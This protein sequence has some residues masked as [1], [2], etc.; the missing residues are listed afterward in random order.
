MG[1]TLNL[2]AVTRPVS[3]SMNACELTHLSREMIDVSRARDQHAAYEGLLASLGCEIV[4]VA[5]ADELPDAVFVED[6]AVV[7]DEVAILTR[8]GAGSRRKEVA[9][10][11]D[12][13]VDHRALRQLEA[14]GTVDGGDVIVHGRDVFVG[15]S[16]RTNDAGIAQLR[17]FLEEYAYVVRPVN[18]VGALHLKTAVTAVADDIQL[19]NPRWLPEKLPVA[20]G[21]VVEV[22]P[23]EPFAANALRIGNTVLHG[24]QFPRTRER[25]EAAGVHTIPV[26]LS[27]LSKAEGGVTCCSLILRALQARSS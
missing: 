8:P 24:A 4:R 23:D 1:E 20:A 27:E 14:P 2:V 25:L 16:A 15:R 11:G 6:T 17:D 19:L 26:D 3:L 9:A 22:H 10:V 13:L 5:A 21:R 18:F 12:A 7:V